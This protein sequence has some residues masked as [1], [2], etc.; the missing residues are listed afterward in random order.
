MNPES[1][2]LRLLPKSGLIPVIGICGGSGSGKTTLIQN[3]LVEPP[4]PFTILSL[5]SYYHD[6]AHLPPEERRLVNFDHPD[7]LDTG[8][9]A[10][11]LSRLSQGKAIDIPLYDFATHTRC[12]TKTIEPRSLIICDGTLILAIPAIPAIREQ[13]D[14]SIFIDTPDDVRL[15][16]RIQRDLIERGRTLDSILDQYLATVRPM[17]HEFIQP[18]KQWADLVLDGTEK[19]EVMRERLM[20]KMKAEMI[21]FLSE[22]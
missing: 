10:E 20:Q 8:L 2:I 12:G 18:S 9:Y 1:E 11:H 17:H 14:L 21:C 19:V 5:D 16:R 22:P 15:I 13:F 7:S 3:L 6:L 4:C